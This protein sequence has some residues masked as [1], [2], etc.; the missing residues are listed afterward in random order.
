[1]SIPVST[2]LQVHNLVDE[3]LA[4]DLSPSAIEVDLP[5]LTGGRTTE[6][7]PGTLSTLLE[8]NRGETE[9][10]AEQLA[11]ALGAGA[12][13]SDLAPGWWGRYPFRAR[14]VA[15]RISVQIE[16]LHA[17]VYALR[18]ALGAVVPVRGSAGVGTVHAVLP[19]TLPPDRIEAILDA[20]RNVL[21]ARSGRAVIIAA[22]PDL[23]RQIGM[24]GRRDL[25]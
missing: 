9:A 8:G 24:A 3:A 18:D 20:V 14:D 2:P 12:T 10:Q 11:K 16:D 22:P 7:P 1:V 23:A 5:A 17:A 6:Q 13:I 15:L 4:Q 25:F 21:M 19:G